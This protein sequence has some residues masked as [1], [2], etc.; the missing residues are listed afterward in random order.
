[1]ILTK[2]AGRILPTR[3]WGAEFFLKAKPANPGWG[4]VTVL[5][6]Q[7][8]LDIVILSRS[9]LDSARLRSVDKSLFREVSFPEKLEILRSTY[10]PKGT[11]LA[12]FSEA[13]LCTISS[14]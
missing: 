7:G 3:T 1:M 6:A 4:L 5:L 2:D 8:S 13:G 12:G 14:L 9:V 10:A 11:C